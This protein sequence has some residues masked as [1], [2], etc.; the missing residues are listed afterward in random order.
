MKSM[1]SSWENLTIQLGLK[2]LKFLYGLKLEEF[3]NI[4]RTEKVK[5]LYGLKLEEFNNRTGTE[6]VKFFFQPELDKR[7]TLSP[8]ISL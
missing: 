3:N 7:E 5:F 2:R 6:R 1:G 8:L 4:T